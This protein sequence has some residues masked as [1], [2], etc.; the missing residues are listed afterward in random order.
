MKIKEMF[1]MIENVNKINELIGDKERNYISLVDDNIFALK[2][3]NDNSR[4]YKLKEI[5]RALNYTY[6]KNEIENIMKIDFI[7][8]EKY[9]NYFEY[10]K[11]EIGIYKY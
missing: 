10:N 7:Q 3:K 5:Q 11:Y 9:K 4:F 2:D 8:N 6:N 1:K